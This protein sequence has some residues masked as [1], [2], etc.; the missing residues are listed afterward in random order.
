M[1]NLTPKD[2]Q[3]FFSK[4]LKGDGCWLW[5]GARVNTGYG[6]MVLNGKF[7]SAHRLS[8]IIHHGPIPDGM[9]VCHRCDVR[10]CVNPDHLFAGTPQDNVTDKTSKGRAIG[11]HKGSSHHKAKLTE[12][13]VSEIKGMFSSSALTNW[14]LGKMYG[15]SEATI[16]DIRLD[17]K[18]RHVDPKPGL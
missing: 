18:W 8:H 2:V 14:R 15:V 1:T 9:Y 17:K 6:K 13:K 3:R 5:T 4:V 16:R 7:V 10:A 12:E 11:A